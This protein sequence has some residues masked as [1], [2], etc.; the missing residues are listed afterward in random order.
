MIGAII[1]QLKTGSISNV[2]NFGSERP[3]P[4]YV[5]VRP[6]ANQNGRLFRIF[7]HYSPDQQAWLEDYAFSEVVTLLDG[8]T[9][10]TRHGNDNQLLIQQDYQDI[11]PYNDDG[12]I[13]MERRFLMPSRT[14]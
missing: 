9:A 10:E 8:F 2:V 4:P 11:I 12:T 6:E 14:F 5:V 13:S 1:T 3:D 7:I